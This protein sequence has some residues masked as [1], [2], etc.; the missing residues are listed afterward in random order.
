VSMEW[1]RASYEMID[2]HC[3]IFLALV[4]GDW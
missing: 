3:A 2:T 4:S 1:F